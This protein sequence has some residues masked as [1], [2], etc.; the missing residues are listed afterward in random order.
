MKNNQVIEYGIKNKLIRPI[1][2]INLIVEHSKFGKGQVEHVENK[3]L[4][5]KFDS[6]GLKKI[7]LDYIRLLSINNVPGIDINRIKN[8][9]YVERK[10]DEYLKNKYK[11][12]NI[13]DS[14]FSI[15]YRIDENNYEKNLSELYS[16]INESSWK[17]IDQ[18]DKEYL[19]EQELRNR[20]LF[21][22]LAIKYE[23]RFNF[24]DKS[25]YWLL[26]NSGLYWRKYR[27]YDRTLSHLE[28]VNKILDERYIEDYK[29]SKE[30]STVYTIIAA[31]YRKLSKYSE[32]KKYGYEAIKYNEDSF[33]AHNVYAAACKDLGLNAESDKHYKIAAEIKSAIGYLPFGDL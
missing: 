25:D 21:Q 26:I 11:V 32:A 9:L 10:L 8:S 29:Y 30:K 22:V 33:Y 19:D 3:I 15:L 17:E 7:G 31:S 6:S 20:G 28:K 5:I 13:D 14:V 12:S 23:D 27:N 4:C 18:F 24:S 1:D 2:L 16:L